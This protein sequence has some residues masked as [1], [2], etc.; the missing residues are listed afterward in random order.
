MSPKSWQP[1]AE[2]FTVDFDIIEADFQQFYNLDVSKVGFRRY[3]RLLLNLPEESRF[4]RKYA[5]LKDWNWDRETQSQILLAIQNLGKIYIDANRKKGRPRTPEIKQMQ[6]DYVAE[7]KK[8]IERER[9]EDA[10]MDL[11]EFKK[12]FENRNYRVTSLEEK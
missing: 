6:P 8:K 4:I 1:C 12:I 5:P 9:K 11:E 7:A 10:G 2:A 3:A